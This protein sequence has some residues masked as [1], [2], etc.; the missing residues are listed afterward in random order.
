M[1]SAFM[2]SISPFLSRSSSCSLSWQAIS[3]EHFHET[4]SSKTSGA[5]ILKGTSVH[6]MFISIDCVSVFPN[7][8]TPSASEPSVDWGIAWRPGHEDKS[9]ASEYVMV[10]FCD[11]LFN[12]DV[13]RC[14]FYHCL[15]L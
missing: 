14:I 10:Y 12:G 5:M 9:Q 1:R 11:I 8:G 13:R 4:N 6:W 15:D 3:E 2:A 7:H